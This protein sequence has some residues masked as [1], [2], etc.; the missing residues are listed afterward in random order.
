MPGIA[1]HDANILI[2]LIR[3]GMMGRC[4]DLPFEFYTSRIV[5][6]ELHD[7]QQAELMMYVDIGQFSIIEIGAE[8]LENI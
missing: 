5:V 2:D 1:I 8:E 3:I 6:D 4:L 7:H